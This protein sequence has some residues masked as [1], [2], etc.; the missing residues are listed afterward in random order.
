MPEFNMILRGDPAPS[1]RQRTTRNPAYAFD[2]T[3]GRYIVLCFLGRA[4]DAH[5]AAAIAAVQTRPD[6]FNDDTGCFFG[7][8]IDPAD[9]AGTDV[10]DVLPGYRY[11]WD[12]DRRVSTLYGASPTGDTPGQGDGIP[13]RRFWV[14]I[15]PT[16]RVMEVIPFQADRSD[17]D[18]MLTTLDRLPPPGRFAGIELQAPIIFLPNVL[19]PDLCQALIRRYETEGGEESGFMREQ[20]GRTVAVSD[21]SHKRRRDCQIN[22][23]ETVSA[24]QARF[25]RRVVPEIAKIHQFHVTRMERYI[26]SCYAA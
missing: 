16:L 4:S 25:L 14:L 13:Y 17:I 8:S 5:G 22:D 15:D 21:H 19:E 10:V 2:T 11:F 20:D 18:R 9:E 12:H 6:F 23:R 1:F 7:V 24:L 26:V 3:A